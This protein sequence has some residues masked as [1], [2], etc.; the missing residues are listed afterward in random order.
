MTSSDATK[1]REI[2]EL[3][4]N[5]SDE[6]ITLMEIAFEDS[7]EEDRLDVD[8]VRKL[9]KRIR[10]PAYRVLTRA[11]G[12]RM[13]FYIAEVEDTIASGILLNIEKDEVYVADLMTLPGYRRIGLARDLLRLSFN[14]ALELG[15]KKVSLGARA[16]NVN[17]VS[18][19][20]SEGFETT[21]HSGR[22]ES[23]TA[24]EGSKSTSSD[25]SIKEINKVEFEEI[26]PMLDDCYPTSHLEIQGR[27]KIVKDYIPSRAIRFFAGRLGGQ[28]I[29]TYA[30][31]V[32]GEEEP[33]GF[34]QASQSK[35]EDRIRLSSPILLEKDNHL[36]LEVIPKVLSIETSYRGITTSSVTSSMHRTDTVSK[37]ESLGFKK[38]RE[39]ISMTK[40]L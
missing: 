28:S 31:Y 13:E 24:I 23:D 2:R 12:M 16:D 40:R 6:F 26:N 10:S 29:N 38:I 36:L 39:N 17:A 14:R 34:I 9:M 4:S 1:T 5:E 20:K 27:D 22:F 3:K 8:E 32:K 21:F 35:I 33:R 7:I 25:C 19:Y 11:V 30:F 37:I 15:I 18:L